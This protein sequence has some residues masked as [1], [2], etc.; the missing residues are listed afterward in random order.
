MLPERIAEG[1]RAL[2]EQRP[3][4]A[5]EALAPVVYDPE[6]QQSTELADVRARVCAL[7]AQALLEDGRIHEA[8]AACRDAL[9]AVRRLG[10]AAGLADV[11]ALQDR[12]VRALAEAAEQARRKV[13]QARVA[14]TPVAELLAG[15]DALQRAEA[16]VKKATACADVGDLD[17]GAPLAR[18]AA[19]VAD[20][21][22]ATT[23]SVF[24]RVALARL[25]PEQAAAHLAQA[26]RLADEADEFN[27]VSAI[28]EAA[29]GLGLPLPTHPGAHGAV[30]S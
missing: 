15:A 20:A 23:W 29:R 21:L 22:G 26:A 5:V 17:A 7:Y 28:A 18:E 10:D 11:R 6:L 4:A 1:V 8:D 9:R 12:I 16:L 25:E 30:E 19:Q 14:A 3:G 27:L 13:E 2:R 24:A